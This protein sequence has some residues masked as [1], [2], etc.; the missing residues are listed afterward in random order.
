MGLKEWF[1]L[2]DTKLKQFHST[3]V[4]NNKYVKKM[5]RILISLAISILSTGIFAGAKENAAVKVNKNE[6]SGSV[7]TSR[8]LVG[9]IMDN[10]TSETLAGAVI[11]F[12]GKKTYSDLDG[13]FRIENLPEGKGQIAISLISYENQNLIVDL[14]KSDL[15]NIKLKQR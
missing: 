11:S 13:N 7:L 4:Q 14:S 9:R 12:N 10:K 2:Y 6:T 3:F 15:L 8:Y 5:K 1:N